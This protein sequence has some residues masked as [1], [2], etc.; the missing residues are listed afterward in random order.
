M[1]ERF[2][3][4]AIG[5]AF[6]CILTAQLVCRHVSHKSVFDL[7]EGNPGMANVAHSL[8]LRWGLYTLGGDIAKTVMAALV[9]WALMPEL[10]W[11]TTALWA[12]LGTTL[13]HTFPAWHH[14]RGGKGVTTTCAG[15]IIATPVAGLVSMLAGGVTVV[16]SGYLCVGA[17]VISAVYLAFSF[18]SG[19]MDQIVV[20]AA[21]G[22]LM[23]RAH[24]PAVAGISTG[25]TGRT[26][27]LGRL[28]RH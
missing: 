15:T 8:G 27:L 19:S 28:R 2:I 17:L 26:D 6:G 5:Y 18:A 25:E 3:C 10:G 22:A 4:L 14:F 23:L 11:T 7:G 12:T 20:A 1:A 21:L 16:G 9:C 13:G 24:A